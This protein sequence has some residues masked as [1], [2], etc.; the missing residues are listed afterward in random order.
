[1]ERMGLGYEDIS[2]VQPRSSTCRCRVSAT[3][4]RDAVRR[5]GRPTRRWPRRWRASTSSP[6][7]RPSAPKINPVG[8]LGDIGSAMIARL[9]MLAALRHRD[10][11]GQ[12]Q[13]VDISMYDSMVAFTDIVHELL[14]DG[15]RPQTRRQARHDPHSFKAT[16]GYFIV[17]VGRRTIRAVRR[18]SAIPSGSP[19]PLRHAQLA[20]RSSKTS[21]VPRSRRGPSTAQARGLLA[22][23]GGCRGRPVPTRPRYRRRA[24]QDRNM[25]SRCRAATASSSRSCPRQPG[26]DVEGA[27]GPE[28]RM[29]WVGEHTAEILPPSSGSTTT[30][31]PAW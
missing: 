24:R 12:G 25:S 20:G 11:H 19:T 22:L 23:G 4:R 10:E 2:A 26:Q 7:P 28:T 15:H 16:D 9:G 27:E 6:A 8:A 17:Q 3:P 14:V 30:S 13:Y 29:P 1:M 5:L 31:S 21:S 18:P